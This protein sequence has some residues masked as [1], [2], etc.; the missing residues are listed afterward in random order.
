[1]VLLLADDL[2]ETQQVLQAYS[3][4]TK[5][6]KEFTKYQATVTGMQRSVM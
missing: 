6:I 4:G 5:A 2:Q 3:I 1:V